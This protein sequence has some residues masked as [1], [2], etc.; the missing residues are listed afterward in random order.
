MS[1]LLDVLVLRCMASG[2]GQR[3][4]GTIKP[5]RLE[6]CGI[7]HIV[8]L[9]SA[10]IVDE[11]RVSFVKRECI[12]RFSVQADLG[13]RSDGFGGARINPIHI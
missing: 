7:P 13:V 12:D 8:C 2:K 4:G 3:Y 11:C 5:T 9:I 1:I 6:A 10:C